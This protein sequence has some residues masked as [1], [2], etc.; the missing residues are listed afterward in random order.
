MEVVEPIPSN[1]GID[2][3]LLRT[4]IEAG[5]NAGGNVY[6]AGELFDLIIAAREGD[7]ETTVPA[8]LFIGAMS[9]LLH[10]GVRNDQILPLST[11]LADTL[12]TLASASEAPLIPLQPDGGEQELIA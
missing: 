4:R 3:S 11:E 2:L 6:T 8:G 10:G 9:L 7:T 5:R 1:H 12:V